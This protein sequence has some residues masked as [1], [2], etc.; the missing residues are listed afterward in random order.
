MLIPYKQLS[1]EALAGLIEEFGTRDGTDNGDET[2]FA[3]RKQR[4]RTALEKQQAVIIYD[5]A[6]QQCQLCLR[7]DVPRT[8]LND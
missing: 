6:S 5:S 7:H 3:V 1:T 8:L 4:V 2:P